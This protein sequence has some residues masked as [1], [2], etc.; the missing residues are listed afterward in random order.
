MGE[1]VFFSRVLPAASSP[2]FLFSP[3]QSHPNNPH[4]PSLSPSPSLHSHLLLIHLA[5]AA[6]QQLL[7]H[8][9]NGQVDNPF[10]ILP[11]HS[12]LARLPGRHHI[13]RL[14]HPGQGQLGDGAHRGR[15]GPQVDERALA[16][17]PGHDAH[18]RVPAGGGGGGRLQQLVEP[19]VQVG[20]G[21]VWWVG[22]VGGGEGWVGGAAH[23]E[24]R[25]TAAQWS[26][27]GG[28]PSLCGAAGAR[29]SSLL[30][31]PPALT[32]HTRAR[33]MRDLA[34]VAR[35]GRRGS[36]PRRGRAGEGK[37]PRRAAKS[38]ARSGWAVAPPS[39]GLGRHAPPRIVAQSTAVSTV[40]ARGWGRGACFAAQFP[41]TKHKLTS[42]RRRSRPRRARHPP[43]GGGLGPGRAP[44]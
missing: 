2:L 37:P 27:G 30:P 26:G 4:S 39:H 44:A 33:A 28:A 22:G 6:P 17:E 7:L 34:A 31:S 13:L 42:T 14:V 16:V 3:P 12:K 5:Q 40:R 18:D 43:R 35:A 41:T 23:E 9:A 1:S 15:L 24:R 25:G 36:A 10:L 38:L 11:H 8:L 29:L 21:A 20:G 32:Q 19:S